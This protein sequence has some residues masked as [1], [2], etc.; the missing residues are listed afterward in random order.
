MQFASNVEVTLAD[1]DLI[2]L[3]RNMTACSIQDAICTS[4]QEYNQHI[5]SLKE[6]MSEATESAEDIRTEI[7]TFRSK[8]VQH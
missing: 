2:A 3:R 6:E 8:S 7:Q 5:D 1:I 4:L